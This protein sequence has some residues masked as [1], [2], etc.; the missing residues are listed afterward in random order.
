MDTLLIHTGPLRHSEILSRVP[1]TTLMA[2]SHT[3]QSVTF[4]TAYEPG[5]SPVTTTP[6]LKGNKVMPPRRSALAALREDEISLLSMAYEQAKNMTRAQARPLVDYYYMLQEARKAAGNQQLALEKAGE[7]HALISWTFESMESVEKEIA[8]L[9]KVFADNEPSGVGV[10]AQSI[11][12]IGPVI[13]AGLLA[14]IDI[15]QAPTVGHIWRFAGLDP[16]STWNKGEKR[17]WNAS[18]KVLAW[19]IGES[20]VKVKGRP[21]DFYGEVYDGRKAYEQAMNDDFKYSDQAAIGAQRVRKETEAYKHYSIGKLPPGHIHARSKRYATKLFLS[22]LHHVM[23]MAE[24]G[25]L[26]PK[27]YILNKPDHVHFMEPPNLE[28]IEP[29]LIAKFPNGEWCNKQS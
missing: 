22:H 23:F 1:A 21:S 24:Y 4:N 14:H 10:W 6:Q 17:P 28:F 3:K 29:F 16:T 19:K 5:N 15:T 11:L 18:L 7:P 26:P 13:S 20:F 27:P 25:K 9:L 8:K 12:G 2:T